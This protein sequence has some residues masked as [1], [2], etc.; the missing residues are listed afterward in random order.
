[1]IPP[2]EFEHMKESRQRCMRRPLPASPVY[3]RL[4]E[5]IAIMCARM[6]SPR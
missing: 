3:I 5:S 4:F 1:M 2:R 6:N